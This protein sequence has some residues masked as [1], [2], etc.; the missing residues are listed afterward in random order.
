MHRSP[1]PES[2]S[3]KLHRRALLLAAAGLLVPNAGCG[4][5]TTMMYW[6]RGNPV[7][8]KFPGLKDKSVAIVVFD[9]NV[10]G[11]EGDM[12]ARRI[13]FMLKTYGKDIK[14]IEHQ[15][16]A[17]WLDK[18]PE[19]VADFKEVGRGVNADMVLCVDLD[20]FSTHEG[21]GLLRGRARIKVKVLDMAKGGKV[22]YDQPMTPV[23]FPESGPRAISED[24]ARFKS[25]FV[26]I[27]AKNIS[28]DFYTY[29][30][31]EDFGT[32]TQWGG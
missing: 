21:P 5:L 22:V 31:M 12:L 16:I 23:L 9:G 7:S 30:R 25:N 13:G 3:L 26:D 27:L 24:E 18:Q 17:D 19:N 11:G 6:A 14:V 1:T 8:A 32:D 4:M 28:K 29:D 15:K 2:T 10:Q 20:Q